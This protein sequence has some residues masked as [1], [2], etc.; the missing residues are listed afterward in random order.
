MLER[1]SEGCLRN[2]GVTCCTFADTK[3]EKVKRGPSVHILPLLF[4]LI[5]KIFLEKMDFED[6]ST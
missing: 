5:S 2:E 4:I 1:N 6:L 3:M